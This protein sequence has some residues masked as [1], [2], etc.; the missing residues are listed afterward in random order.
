MIFYK[1]LHGLTRDYLVD[2]VLPLVQ[3][4]SAY[5]LR[6]ADHFQTS[7]VNTNLFWDS[8]FPSVIQAWNNLPYTTKQVT[9][10]AS[11]KYLLNRNLLRPLNDYN[12]GSRLGQILNARVRM[13]CSSFNSEL[14]RKKKNEIKKKENMVDSPFCQCGSFE[15]AYHFFFTCLHFATERKTYLPDNLP[16]YSARE[17]L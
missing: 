3:E 5:N 17:L 2:L 7:R 9:S 15:S 8:F 11:F 1:I 13:Q 14:Y 10:V 6:N 16:Y 4:S 12:V